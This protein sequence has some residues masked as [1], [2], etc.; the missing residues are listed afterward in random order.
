[1][2][3]RK[4]TSGRVVIVNAGDWLSYRQAVNPLASLPPEGDVSQWLKDGTDQQIVAGKSYQITI[5]LYTLEDA[6]ADNPGL[7]DE[8]DALAQTIR[9]D[10]D[11]ADE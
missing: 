3:E 7:A 1:M 8:L 9:S 2:S 4:P 11:E 6:M 10:E 5:K